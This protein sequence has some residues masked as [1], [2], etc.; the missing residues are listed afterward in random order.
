MRRQSL[1]L[2]TVLPSGPPR[3]SCRPLHRVYLLRCRIFALLSGMQSKKLT[4]NREGLPPETE[5]REEVGE[6]D[7]MKWEEPVKRKKNS[8]VRKTT[9]DKKKKDICFIPP[10]F[11]PKPETNP[12]NREIR[13]SGSSW[14]RNTLKSGT[15]KNTKH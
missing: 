9:R 7:G 11:I 6:G 4:A 13:T 8:H 14:L 1:R 5:N 15:T 2:V 10:C 3:D 12:H